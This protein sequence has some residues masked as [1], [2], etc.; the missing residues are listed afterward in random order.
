MVSEPTERE[1]LEGLSEQEATHTNYNTGE[2][3]FCD[4]RFGYLPGPCINED[5]MV[6]GNDPVNGTG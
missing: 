3:C 6:G 4:A 5:P 1:W 2:P